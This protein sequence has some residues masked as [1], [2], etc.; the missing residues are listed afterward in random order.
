[1]TD[2]DLSLLPITQHTLFVALTRPDR[3]ALEREAR[4]T[5]TR[6]AAALAEAVLGEDPAPEQLSDVMNRAIRL[7]AA[8]L[9]RQHR[10]A[11]ARPLIAAVEAQA[12]AKARL[13]S[14]D[15]FD[16]CD[17]QDRDSGPPPKRTEVAVTH[18]L[19]DRDID[20]LAKLRACHPSDT[21]ALGREIRHLLLERLA[22]QR[23]A[24]RDAGYNTDATDFIACITLDRRDTET[25]NV[26]VQ[27]SAA[28]AGSSPAH[29]IGHIVRTALAERRRTWELL[30][31]VTPAAE[32]VEAPAAES[33][34]VPNFLRRAFDPDRDRDA[35]ALLELCSRLGCCKDSLDW[36]RE[37]GY[38]SLDA[39]DYASWDW[40]VTLA[41]HLA[42]PW[43]NPPVPHPELAR[44]VVRALAEI[45]PADD[46][47]HL[48]AALL[49]CSG[50]PVDLVLARDHASDPDVQMLLDIAL[51]FE[52]G[53]SIDDTF[54][55][56]QAAMEHLGDYV[57]DQAIENICAC[58]PFDVLAQ[59][60]GR[61]LGVFRIQAYA[62]A[63]AGLL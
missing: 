16:D 60:A 56:L 43:G 45:V 51:L 41:H 7:Y 59:A 15:P 8:E 58:L 2:A 36:L 39:Y 6:N 47:A 21:G 44:R 5:A 50:Q 37:R 30:N 27:A 28:I 53:A 1:M 63:T 31:E 48:D 33:A 13:A 24:W 25:L 14:A 17:P 62:R 4:E 26:L 23:R 3:E 42:H 29:E 52:Q 55:A 12:A 32:M 34:P 22:E 19:S 10:A 38:D 46:P 57:D 61:V 9:R 11:D 18:Y 54:K 49:W 20:T 40:L 35:A